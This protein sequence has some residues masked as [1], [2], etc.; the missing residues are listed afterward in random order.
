MPKHAETIELARY[1]CLEHPRTAGVASR[2]PTG[3]DGLQ[4][5]HQRLLSPWQKPGWCR[6]MATAST[7]LPTLG[8][9][10][11]GFR[12]VHSP[13]QPSMFVHQSDCSQI[14]GF[15]HLLDSVHLDSRSFS[16]L[17]PQSWCI[18][19]NRWCVG[20]HLSCDLATTGDVAQWSGWAAL[21]ILRIE[22]SQEKPT[23]T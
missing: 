21:G 2:R 9:L 8:F 11:I 5:W 1:S 10:S 3:G 12:G 4:G 20:D 23:T 13:L 18:S 15:L 17:L 7:A 22:E 6:I 14:K 19:P 16:S